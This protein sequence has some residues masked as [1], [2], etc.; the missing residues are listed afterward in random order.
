M[1]VGGSVKKDL[2]QGLR[3]DTT[4]SSYGDAGKGRPVPSFMKV[5]P[6]QNVKGQCQ[7]IISGQF[8]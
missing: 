8:F 3:K 4:T 1:N 5:R 6:G 2:P 7:R